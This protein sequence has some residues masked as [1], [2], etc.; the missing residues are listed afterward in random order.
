MQ[1]QNGAT[2]R[3]LSCHDEHSSGAKKCRTC[4]V[5]KKTNKI[6]IEDER[7][8]NMKTPNASKQFD[9]LKYRVRKN[10]M[11]DQPH[12]LNMQATK[13]SPTPIMQGHSL[14]VNCRGVYSYIR[15]LPDKFLLKVI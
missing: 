2:K 15:D 8:H 3:C 1:T 4:L 14:S 10:Y 6:D 12:P 7:I 13:P 5:Q 11:N 9:K